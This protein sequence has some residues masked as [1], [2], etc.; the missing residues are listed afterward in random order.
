MSNK[1]LY[2][3]RY[4]IIR[5]SSG[6]FAST[7]STI[8]SSRSNLK[9]LILTKQGDRPGRPEYGSSF[10]KY[11]FEQSVDSLSDIISDVLEED[12]NK[13]MP[14]IIVD[15]ISVTQT[16]DSADIY[17]LMIAVTFRLNQ[18][19]IPVTDTTAITL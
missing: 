4:P 15:N 2:G 19:D 5:D 13:W 16:S 9:N 3:I 1:I 6:Y 7:Y 12:I 17:K 11:L 10:W 8:E 14:E 18:N